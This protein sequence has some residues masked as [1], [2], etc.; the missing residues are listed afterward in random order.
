M[1]RLTL[2]CISFA[3]IGLLLAGTISAKIDRE[4]VVGMW[5][6]DNEN[7]LAVDMSRNGHDGELMGNVQ[8]VDGIFGK[9]V[10]FPG[11]T[12]S[13][14]NIPDDASLSLTTFSFV[15]WIRMFEPGQGYMCIFSKAANGTPQNYAG[16]LNEGNRIFWGRFTCGGPTSWIQSLAGKTDVSNGDWHHL[17]VTYDMK[18]LKTYINGKLEIELETDKT[19]DQGTGALTFGISERR[20]DA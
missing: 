10:E 8:R 6:F 9:A 12:D 3:L 20:T 17:A 18:S 13:Y 16:F 1:A 7:E 11:T 19:P 14:I 2:F 15:G 5:L 4:S